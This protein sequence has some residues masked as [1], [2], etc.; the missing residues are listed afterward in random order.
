MGV[1][2]EAKAKKQSK[3]AKKFLLL[4]IASSEKSI[5][6]GSGLKNNTILLH[7]LVFQQSQIFVCLNFS[8]IMLGLT[9]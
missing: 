7:K 9:G 8:H 1:G 4:R 5:V 2:L 3:I 6:V